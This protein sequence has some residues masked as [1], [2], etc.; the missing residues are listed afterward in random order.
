MN[1]QKTVTYTPAPDI[2]FTQVNNEL[3]LYDHNRGLHEGVYI[4][5][6]IGAR[7]WQLL[8]EYGNKELVTHQLR[9]EYDVDQTTVED[10]LNSLIDQLI[11]QGFLT[12]HPSRVDE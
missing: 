4:L 7:I 6:D 9:L 5:D 12:A 10:E 3:V 1:N 8:V 11:E 2:L